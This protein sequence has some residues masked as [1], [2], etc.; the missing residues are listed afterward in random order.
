ML[1]LQD[2]LGI[3]LFHQR[4]FKLKDTTLKQEEFGNFGLNLKLVE[5]F[6][7]LNGNSMTTA[8][9]S[10]YSI[11]GRYID[12]YATGLKVDCTVLFPSLFPIIM[13]P[14]NKEKRQL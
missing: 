3:G 11:I 2:D 7:I 1:V 9:L 8:Q 12:L 10:L 5:N 13:I 4:C 14:S 6:E